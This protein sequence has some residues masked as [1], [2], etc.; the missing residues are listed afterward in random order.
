MRRILALLATLLIALPAT[1]MPGPDLLLHEGSAAVRPD[2]FDVAPCAQTGPAKLLVKRDMETA[3]FALV[4]AGGCGPFALAF[5]G[6][7]DEHGWTIGTPASGPQ[8]VRGSFTPSDDHLMWTL[9][10]R[11]THCPH[12]LDCVQPTLFVVHGTFGPGSIV[13]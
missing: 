3:Q 10:L 12:P 9:H 1:A 6:T 4:I 13:L 7:L 2:P 5:T 8:L 11:V